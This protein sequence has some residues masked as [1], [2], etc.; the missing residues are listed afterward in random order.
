MNH[1]SPSYSGAS[2]GHLAL[3]RTHRAV[4]LFHRWILSVLLRSRLVFQ[5][6]FRSRNELWFRYFFCSPVLWLTTCLRLKL[7]ANETWIF[8]QIMTFQ[9]QE[10]TRNRRQKLPLWWLRIH[11][12]EVRLLPKG[13]SLSNLGKWIFLS[14]SIKVE[15]FV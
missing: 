11:F 14:L 9:R 6:H 1:N 7:G 4:E 12:W 10:K 13:I 8:L 5:I 15:N 3:W 2:A